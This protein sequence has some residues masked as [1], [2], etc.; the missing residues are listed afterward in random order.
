M[1]PM[2][3]GSTERFL[4]LRVSLRRVRPEVW[5]GLVVPS[6]MRLSVFH[7]V[8]QLA[9]G[10]N[11]S[12]LHVF[13]HGES[14]YEPTYP[15]SSISCSLGKQLDESAFAIGDLLKARRDTLDYQYDMGDFWDHHVVVEEVVD[16]SRFGRAVCVAGARAAPPD[17]CGGAAGYQDL[18]RILANPVH[19]QFS[20]MMEW[21]GGPIDPE[22]FDMASINR[23]LRRL[24]A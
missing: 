23:A 2:K 15:D 12:H 10:W 16:D 5:R 9:F 14:S 7:E 18:L 17:G 20:D 21:A 24:R 11:N 13:R 1:T 19:P 3:P 4:Q 22:M 6:S 8:L